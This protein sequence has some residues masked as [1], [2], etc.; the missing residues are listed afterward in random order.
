VNPI[1]VRRGR[2]KQSPI[3]DIIA[4]T[5]KFPWWVGIS[6]AVA[7]YLILH[8][9]ASVP[10]GS[11]PTDV[12]QLGESAAKQLYTTLALYFQYILP[13]VFVIGSIVSAIGRQ[14]RK[15]L[16]KRAGTGDDALNEM[17][18]HE[19]EL[20]VGEYFRH[21]GFSVKE[22]G[23]S[24]PDGGVDLIVS[25][26]NDRYVVQCKKWRA[27]QVGVATVRE[28]YGV[29]GATGAAG[30]FVVTSGSFTKDAARFAEGR[31]IELVAADYLLAEVRKDRTAPGLASNV[32]TRAH[33]PACPDCGSPMLLKTARKGPNAGRAFWGCSTYP[34]CRGTRQAS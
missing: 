33:S 12:K 21:R 5:A 19:F 31:E 27:K 8:A 20:L 26:G 4:V 15:A 30:A 29:M 3:E 13:A 11:A 18:W 34:E 16:F 22:M 14:K 28:L 9:V 17:T 6:L 7:A 10:I 25:T 1:W 24:G 2:R 32:A 23:G